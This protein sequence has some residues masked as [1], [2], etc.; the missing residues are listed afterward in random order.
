[1]ENNNF[2]R[3]IEV[4]TSAIMRNSKGEIL[5]ARSPKW[6]NKWTLP[7]GH[8]EPG[9]TIIEAA[10]REAK[11][12][13]GLKLKPGKIIHFGELINSEGFQRP[14]HFIYF[15]VVFDVLDETVTLDERELTEY[16]WVEPEEALSLDLADS[17]PEV[18]EAYLASRE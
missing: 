16:A 15:N 2:P 18:L 8:V 7:G 13:T 1:M 9:E 3:G 4:V 6:G 14:A 17:Y 12:E 10:W 11:E 5:L